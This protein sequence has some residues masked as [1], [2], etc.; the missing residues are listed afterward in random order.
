MLPRKP[1]LPACARTKITSMAAQRAMLGRKKVNAAE[2]YEQRRRH[3]VRM[4]R[5]ENFE[6]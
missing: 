5:I 6:F 1:P 2:I 4:Q 3:E